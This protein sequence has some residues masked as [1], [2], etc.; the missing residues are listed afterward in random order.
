M[1]CKEDFFK[2]VDHNRLV[3]GGQLYPI[4]ANACS[5]TGNMSLS[6]MTLSLMTLSLMTLSL[7][8]LSLM[9]L[10]LMT[11]SL[12][13]LSLMMLTIMTLSI[14]TLSIMMLSIMTLSIMTL[15]I[16]TLSIMTL[17]II[18]L[19]IKGFF[20]WDSFQFIIAEGRESWE[21]LYSDSP[22]VMGVMG[23]GVLSG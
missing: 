22:V 11:L 5:H 23:N 10:S 18:T 19:S 9:T 12:M 8:T 15:S 14:M 4:E 3:Q 20:R 17:I 13:T 21:R 16:M 6:L 7:M 2:A 1:F